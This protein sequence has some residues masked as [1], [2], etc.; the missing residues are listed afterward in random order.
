MP[1]KPSQV[2]EE[3]REFAALSAQLEMRRI[4]QYAVDYGGAQVVLECLLDQH[5]APALG[6][7]ID[8]KG[9]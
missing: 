5:P 6:C 8:D 2:G 7:V 9:P 3:D 1:E 4:G